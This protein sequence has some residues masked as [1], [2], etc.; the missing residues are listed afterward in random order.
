MWR[1]WLN[2][3]HKIKA[4]ALK[5]SLLINQKQTMILCLMSIVMSQYVKRNFST[6]NAD[7]YLMKA[8]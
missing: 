8:V 3:T 1:D 7:W 4:L 5:L 2:S 6:E